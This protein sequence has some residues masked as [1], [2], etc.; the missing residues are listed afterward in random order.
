MHYP[1][2]VIDDTDAYYSICCRV[3]DRQ[4]KFD[5]KV[6]EDMRLLLYDAADFSGVDVLDH[7]FMSNHFHLEVHVPP[8]NTPVADDV[9][10]RRVG[11]LYGEKRKQRLE[12]QIEALRDSGDDDGA[13]GLLDSFRSRMN[14]LSEFMKTFK[15]RFTMRYNNDHKRTGTLWEGRFRSTLLEPTPELLRK[16]A[17]Y[18]DL[19]PMRAGM[20]TNPE[21]YLWC[22][23]GA[24]SLKGKR[25]E[26]A[27]EGL[28]LLYPEDA[29]EVFLAKHRKLLLARFEKKGMNKKRQ[30]EPDVLDE[31]Y[32]RRQSSMT[33][34]RV[35]GSPY[36]VMRV[37]GRRSSVGLIPLA[38]GYVAVGREQKR[39]A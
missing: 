17:A 8:K 36:F 6:K 34:S 29:P 23:Y 39:R 19:N 24:A 5:E 30:P 11:I 21:D 32:S 4:F 27:R 10:L 14:D 20:V 33:G 31:D 7:V 9:V 15:Q 26:K 38:G 3:V 1:R 37:T 13:E 18:M 2:L 25:G 16:T 12:E 22:G 28:A 35:I